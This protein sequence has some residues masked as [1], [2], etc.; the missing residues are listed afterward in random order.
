MACASRRR[1]LTYFELSLDL[2]FKDEELEDA[3]RFIC[4]HHVKL[5]HRT[6]KVAF[7]GKRAAPDTRPAKAPNVVVVYCDKPSNCRRSIFLTM[8]KANVCRKLGPKHLYTFHQLGRRDDDVSFVAP[9]LLFVFLPPVTNFPL[10]VV[11][12][13]YCLC[14]R[15]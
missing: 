6:Q 3:Y 12:N 2:I 1:R 8:F 10:G 7:A 4:E 9:P 13:L 5:Y 15:R 14:C 11:S